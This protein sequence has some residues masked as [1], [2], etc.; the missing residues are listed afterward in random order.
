MSTI[1]LVENSPVVAEL[2]RDA[3]AKAPQPG[4]NV[5]H[6]ARLNEAVKWLSEGGIDA[7][8]LD[9]ELPDSNGTDTLAQISRAAP[10]TPVV[11]LTSSDDPSLVTSLL[12]LGMQNYLIK[13]EISPSTLAGMLV[14][15]IEHK[16]VLTEL[17]AEY[18]IG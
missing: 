13:T 5:V 16:R 2:I 11:V 14:C 17:Q 3:L 4:F 6:V 15:S 9:L 7:V 18:M 8:L 10:E 12:R 1:L